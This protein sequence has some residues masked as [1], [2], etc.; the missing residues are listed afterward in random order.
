MKGLITGRLLLRY[1]KNF[2]NCKNTENERRFIDYYCVEKKKEGMV[3]IKTI[4]LHQKLIVFNLAN[5]S[6]WK[7]ISV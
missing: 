3:G 1:Q 5:V 2:Q 6:I 4:Q 7:I